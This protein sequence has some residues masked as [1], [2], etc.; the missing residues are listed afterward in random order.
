VLIFLPWTTLTN[1]LLFRPGGLFGISWRNIQTLTGL[2]RE[3]DTNQMHTFLVLPA[4]IVTCYSII[5]AI[6]DLTSPRM[7]ST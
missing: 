1:T 2:D 3:K 5:A 6:G 7:R 4:T